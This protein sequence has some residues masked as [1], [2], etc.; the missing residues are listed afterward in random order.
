M[1]TAKK[2]AVKPGIRR[3]QPLPEQLRT[4][5]HQVTQEVVTLA[6]EAKRK[7]DGMD[8][9]TKRKVL[10]GLSGAAAL[11]ALRAHHRHK[12]RSKARHQK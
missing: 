12:K 2:R 7:F 11:L 5:L 3:Q 9:A 4:A 6:K 1:A 8:E 10:T